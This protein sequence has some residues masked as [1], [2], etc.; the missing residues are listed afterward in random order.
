MLLLRNSLPLV[1]QVID[2]YNEFK[3]LWVYFNVKEQSE[4]WH[5]DDDMKSHEPSWIERIIDHGIMDHGRKRILLLWIW[6]LQKIYPFAHGQLKDY[7][8][9]T[10][11]SIELL[12][13]LASRVGLGKFLYIS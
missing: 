7:D 5:D 8:L 4:L 2:K 3:W 1:V 9:E 12:W 11:K 6:T 13:K 10:F